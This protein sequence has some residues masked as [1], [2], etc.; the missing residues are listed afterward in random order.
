MDG[1]S[2]LHLNSSLGNMRWCT[3]IHSARW[4][5][6]DPS[7]R[8]T[9]WSITTT[10][11]RFDQLS[12]K[13][14]LELLFAPAGF[15]KNLEPSRLLSDASTSL[16]EYS[17]GMEQRFRFT[18]QL[19]KSNYMELSR[20]RQEGASHHEYE[21]RQHFNQ[22]AFQ[23]G[24]EM[25]T[26]WL[27]VWENRCRLQKLRSNPQIPPRCGIPNPQLDCFVLYFFS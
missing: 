24:A 4:I 23:T 8:S 9:C 18:C 12:L 13:F 21:D 14:G 25:G 7:S 20:M 16:F 11:L 3:R 15:T 1:E 5:L 27:G 22:T 6:Q 19:P 17:R 10:S 26:V 2:L